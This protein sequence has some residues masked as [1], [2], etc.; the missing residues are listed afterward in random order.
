MPCQ[1]GGP[2]W[3]YVSKMEIDNVTDVLCRT[4]KHL[5]ETGYDFKKLHNKVRVWWKRHKEADR[6]RLAAKEK[7]DAKQNLAKAARAKLT[8]EEI[9]ALREAGL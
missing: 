4:L 9:R 6:K 1:D 3:D 5:E 2:S 7:E 8:P